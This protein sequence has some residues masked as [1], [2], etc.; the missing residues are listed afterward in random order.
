MPKPLIEF[1]KQY[2]YLCFQEELEAEQKTTK[3]SI[4]KDTIFYGILVTAI[5][6][7]FIYS[8]ND[9]A[10]KRFGPFAYNTVLTGSMQSVYPKGSLVLSWALK[11]N[12][13]LR[14]GLDIGDDIVFLIKGDTTVVHRILNITENYEDSGQRMFTTQG[15]ENPAPDDYITYEDNVLGRVIFHIP[16]LGA[17]LAFIAEKMIW[18]IAGTIILFALSALLRIVFS[19][20]DGK[21]KDEKDDNAKASET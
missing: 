2:D 11:P 15:V 8:K 17:M 12:E 18:F 7:A 3:G 4:V 5:I 16:Y 1:N 20:D 21:K 14:T 19:D 6:F 10:G 13:Q 9:E